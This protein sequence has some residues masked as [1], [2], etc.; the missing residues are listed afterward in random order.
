MGVSSAVQNLSAGL[1]SY[2]G[3]LILTETA[4][5]RLKGYGPIGWTSAVVA[6]VSLGF[7]FTLSLAR[8][9]TADQGEILEPV[10]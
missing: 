9:E 7:C 4:N 6:L 1:G 8:E 2:F 3:G 10:V 5:G